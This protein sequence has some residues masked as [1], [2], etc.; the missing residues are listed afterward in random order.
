MKW[1]AIAIAAAALVAGS[2]RANADDEFA[3]AV[4]PILAR[5]CAECHGAEDAEQGLDLSTATSVLAGSATAAVIEP[6]NSAESLLVQSL[7]SEADPHMPPDGQLSDDEV[8][9]VAAWI[10]SLDPATPVGSAGISEADRNHWA[11]RPL[12]RPPVPDGN[13]EGWSNTPIDR[14]VWAKLKS[15]GLSPSESADRAVLL[16]RMYFDLIGL[17]PTPEEVAAFVGDDSND[18]V[19]RVVD[20]LL[21]SPQYGE[22]WGRHW[23][24]L[25]RYADSGGFH[26]DL[27]RP[28]AWRYRDYVIASFNADK[29]YAQFVREQIA[30][31]ELPDATLDTWIATG[32]CRNGP[33]N[34]DNMGKG[35][36]L[37]KYRM[38]ELDDIISTTGTVFLGLT[39]GCARCHDHKYDP[40]SQ[41][42]YYR[43]L[44][45]F[46][47]AE[48]RQLELD[49]FDADELKLRPVNGKPDAKSPLAMV[50]TSHGQPSRTTRL[51]WRGDV[52]NPG[53]VV[54]PH[55]PEV[56]ES[57]HSAFPAEA[58]R[59]IDLADWITDAENP[60]TWRVIANRVWHYH[61]GSG[62]VATPSNFGRLGEPPTHPELLDWLAV[63]FRDGGGSL[64]SLHRLIVTSAV[65]Q[66]ASD[67]RDDAFAQ[68]P[69]NRL[70]WRMNRRRLEAESLRD[71][72]LSVA[73]SLNPQ[74]GGPGVHPRI[75]PDLLVASQRNKWPVVKREG[76]EHWRRSVYVYVKRQLQLP[77][78]ELFDA[79]NTS[80]SCPVRDNSLVPTQS[81]VLL[82]DEFVREQAARFAD[83]ARHDAGDDARAQV[84][85]ALWIALGRPP[86][87]QRV[88]EGV[89][90]VGEQRALLEQE[91][92]GAEAAGRAALADLCHV[93]MNLSE[94]VYVD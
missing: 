2:V 3:R 74:A 13:D 8:R 36:A 69:E 17:P 84:E 5:H 37:E 56:L 6:G 67:A 77:L 23:L 7:A 82:N 63:E 73:G 78:L 90:F 48:K 72:F 85:R 76:A 88:V 38:D 1:I 53:P 4:Q 14:F 66:Q 71:A 61:F 52:R 46:H 32:F 80:H 45:F 50:L 60:L 94:F 25:A 9:A 65:Y 79:P 91:G 93:L 10:D 89:A 75:R 57:S 68:D 62:L 54:K 12:V 30:G 26:N 58:A 59:R 49:S 87:E 39:I 42:D 29:P 31:D 19:D 83:R 40:L 86:S 43:F 34:D 92:M 16:R 44:A 22:R 18:A 11:F 21:A 55:V 15:A 51:L 64:K 27:D 47:G 33:S 28:H 70:L 20:R 81:L 35:I 41:R 24:D